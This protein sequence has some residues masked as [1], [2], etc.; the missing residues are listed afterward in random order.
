MKLSEIVRQYRESHAL[1]QRQF[2]AKC[3]GLTNGYISMIENGKNPNNNKPLMP[4][5]AKLKLLAFGMDLSLDDLLALMDDTRVTVDR[6]ELD[7][8][9]DTVFPISSIKPQRIPLIGSI[10]AGQPILAEEEYETFV[11]APNKADYALRVEGDSMTPTFLDG[12]IIYI[13]SVSDIDDGKIGVVLLDDSAAV[14]HIYHI[15]NGLMLTSD[16]PKY[17]PINAT[18]ENYDNIRILGEVVSYTR[19]F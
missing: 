2:A 5:L 11:D 19:M 14:K 8:L 3:Q 13:R 6:D 16:N 12:D 9:P 15:D 18:F 1:S 10:A 4:S 17:M 7:A